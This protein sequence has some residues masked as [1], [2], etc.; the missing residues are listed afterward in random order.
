MLPKEF[1]YL[2]FNALYR[3]LIINYWKKKLSDSFLALAIV[4]TLYRIKFSVRK[5]IAKYAGKL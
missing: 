3:A 1:I 4:V 5:N 2:I